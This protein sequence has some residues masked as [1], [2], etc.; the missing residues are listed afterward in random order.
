MIRQR[1]V[2]RALVEATKRLVLANEEWNADVTQIVGRPPKWTDSYL[3]ACR[4]ALSLAAAYDDADAAPSG[5]QR[6]GE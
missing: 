2:I 1:E 5:A 6:S 4:A 3:D